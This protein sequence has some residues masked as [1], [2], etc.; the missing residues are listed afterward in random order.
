MR[1]RLPL[2]SLLLSTFFLAVPAARLEA[3]DDTVCGDRPI[4]EFRVSAIDVTLPLN[5]W[6]DHLPEGFM[7]AL[8]VNIPRIRDFEAAVAR[9]RQVEP[10]AGKPDAVARI[11]QGL[12]DDPI[13]PLVL[14][15]RL[16]E[17]L[18]VVLTNRLGDGRPVAFHVQG[19][20]HTAGNAGGK[21]GLNP[22]SF[23][24]AGGTVVV[25][26]AI[27]E[28]PSAEGAYLVQDHGDVWE[29]Q[30]RGLFG[31]VVVEPSDAI[32]LDAA[33]GDLLGGEFSDWEAVV[34][35][36]DGGFREF[37]LFHHEIDAL[38]IRSRDGFKVPI[39][40]GLSGSF[41]PLNHALSYR[42]E[43]LFRRY[44]L[45]EALNGDEAARAR[46]LARSS[47]T[48]GDP[49]TPMP[50]AY[51][52]EK[53]KI[54]V[55]HGSGEFVHAHH[56]NGLRWRR[57]RATGEG[58]FVDTEIVGPA[59]S[60]TLEPE[61][62][63]GGCA[64]SP[65]D[66]LYRCEIG[67]HE[68]AG[69]WGL[70]RVFNTI[71]T[72]GENL[73]GRPL[74][75][76][77]GLFAPDGPGPPQAA[78]SAGELA[79]D[80][81]DLVGHL[82]PPGIRLDADDAT[83]WNWAIYETGEIFRILG[84]PESMTAFA[85]YVPANPGERPEVFFDPRTG[86][87]AWPFFRPHAGW[88]PVFAPGHGGD[89]GEDGARRSFPLSAI[90]LPIPVTRD[91]S[92]PDGRLYVLNEALADVVAGVQPAEPLVVRAS[93]GDCIET[94]FTNRIADGPLNKDFSKS[95]L[96]ARLLSFDP[97]TSSGATVGFGYEM[98]VRSIVSEERRLVAAAPAGSAV[99]TVDSSA[100]LQAGVW[101][102]IGLGEGLCSAGEEPR[103]CTEIRR[104]AAIIGREI[105][106]DRPLGV[107]HT[108][109][110]A[111]GVELVRQVW[112]ADTELGAVPLRTEVGFRDLDHGLFGALVVE[113][114]GA[115]FLDPASGEEIVSGPAAD[116]VLP[117][118]GPEENP[119]FRELV[120]M[121]HDNSP[122]EGRFHRGGGTINL[123]AEPWRLREGD[124]SL[125]FS[126]VR[127]G[128]PWT[129]I[130][131]A[132]A[133][134]PVKIRAV[135]RVER[136]AGLRLTGHRFDL[137]GASIP[138][139]PS[140]TMVLGAGDRLDVDVEGGAGGTGGFAGDY[141]FYNTIGRSFE[142][143]AWGLLRVH[144]TLRADLRPLAGR[145]SPP[146]GEGFPTLGVTGER[147]PE[148]PGS[149]DSC[150]SSATR[151]VYE[152]TIEEGR[153]VWNGSPGDPDS[154]R[155]EEDGVFFRLADSGEQEIAGSPLVLRLN[156]GSCL[157]LT[158][159]NRRFSRSG[160]H[161]GE[162]VFDPQQAFGAPIGLNYDSTVFPGGSRVYE[163][164]ADRELGAVV[165][166]DLADPDAAAHGA[167]AAVLV[168]PSGASYRQPGSFEPL[169][170]GGAGTEAD[171]RVPGVPGAVREVV[172]VVSERER[173][174]GQNTM[175]HRILL[176][177]PGGLNYA[178]EPLAR[179]DHTER[180]WAVFDS[181]LWEDPA[182]VTQIPAGTPLRYHLLKPW[183]EQAQ[184]PMI[185]G[186]RFPWSAGDPLSVERYAAPLLPGTAFELA[187]VGGAGGGSGAPG[188][189][190]VSDRRYPFLLA[191]FWNL[192]RVTK[193]P[194]PPDE[195]RISAAYLSDGTP[196]LGR[197]LVVEG[198]NGPQADGGLAD[199]VTIHVGVIE[200]GTCLGRLLG[201]AEIR[202]GGHWRFLRPSTGGPARVCVRSSGGGAPVREVD[203]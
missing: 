114:E 191:G 59:A 192:L 111:V 83:V 126:S 66:F 199:F 180:P 90:D 116:I 201:R 141:L 135:G 166:F 108:A 35:T 15:V 73:Y 40:D 106:L 97:S 162:L 95:S 21:V 54:R 50:R 130:F 134:D 92:D 195:V 136:F 89:C 47:Y 1:E 112:R 55:L 137:R 93:A 86:Q 185:E 173:I 17:C 46:S 152:I 120:M 61:C 161:V 36:P 4:R 123:R 58:P 203:R 142:S 96:G 133:G 168:E 65:G 10:V 179:R 146:A 25:E 181:E 52:G 98:S 159:H 33:T 9:D 109:G 122:V 193:A 7:F 70:M 56:Q 30:Q 94:I 149:G 178:A 88:R 72:P 28:T 8:D 151:F 140:D 77:P 18:R 39:V 127:H 62:G 200:D 23:T 150:P 174:V 74:A 45:D 11:A 155:I 121:L 194:G 144:D 24:A 5:R 87:P 42:S 113:P 177:H 154:P 189:H 139:G 158:V 198:E 129:S 60:V 138:S 165:A 43:A 107:S 125:R 80:F 105:T 6:G 103:A 64:A 100:R 115:F 76:L 167:V 13:Q 143:G 19:L 67:A 71:Q 197:L 14:R 3:V 128:D 186:H 20:P 32:F 164:L 69:A 53:L 44:E 27:P 101:I 48:F 182:R 176:D 147:P 171:V 16:G 183:G 85:N 49:S 153:I 34:L 117:E 68:H 57:D 75:V 175:P 22:D 37:V 38:S 184:S 163:Y 132:Y 91:R 2:A 31:A 157:L 145:P 202:A 119:A 187:L 160:F 99:I 12:G 82:P 131:R 169:P 102:G 78:V 170:A 41:H 104:V 26:L 156:H 172:A 118:P 188:D 148:L 190:L 81:D 63:A 29:R 110:E 124:P 84:E 196:R 79:I 51:V